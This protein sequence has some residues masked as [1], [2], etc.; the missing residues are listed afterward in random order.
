MGVYADATQ[1]P[2]TPEADVDMYVSTDPSLTNLNPLVVSNCVNGTQVGVS[3][4]G[5][6]NG[7]SLSS[8]GTQYVVD[9]GSV[10]GQTYYVG[11]KSETALAGEYGF[12]PVFSQQPFSQ[13]QNGIETVN[14]LLLP[15]LI[16]DGSPA[17]PGTRYVFALAIQPIEVQDVVVSN[18][19]WHQNF[20]DLIGTLSHNSTGVV[21]NNHDSLANPPGPYSF[22][23]YD[24]PQPPQTTVALNTQPTD[25]PGSLN[26]FQG[27]QGVGPWILTEVD[28]ALTHTGAVWG[29]TVT[30]T[31]HTPLN[32][33]INIS[34][35]A[36]GYFY[37]FIDVPVGTT[38]LTLS[39]TNVSG[40]V[41]D[42]NHYILETPP[43]GILYEKLGQ[44][45]APPPTPLTNYDQSVTVDILGGPFGP[46]GSI[47][48]TPYDI[49]PIE[50][51]R[52]YV[53]LYNP[54]AYAQQYQIWATLGIGQVQPVNFA[55]VG[56]VPLLDDAVSDAY[57]S[58]YPGPNATNETIAS[59]AVGIRVDHPRISDLVFTLI[60]PDGTRYLLMQNRG[61]TSTNGAGVTVVTTNIFSGSASGGPEGATNFYDLH[62]TSGTIPITWNFFT[63]AGH[64]GCLLSGHKH[65]QHG[66]DQRIGSH[67][68]HFWPR[69]LDA[70]R[71]GDGCHEPSG[72]HLVDLHHRRRA[73]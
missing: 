43:Y 64:H 40:S 35:S 48:V 47:F 20:G 56:S 42:P 19:I 28:D 52:Y 26:E 10:Q 49:P 18:L 59:I 61:N 13:T 44:Q 8:D 4:G 66:A 3:A 58:N 71:G 50:P 55:P 39:A 25:G 38:N 22:N 51:G 60:S 62:Q 6:F 15:T 30:L 2:T 1:N 45:P 17:H 65:F 41:L 57:I 16:P 36:Y 9:T 70:N 7:S 32:Q 14:G 72:L 46:G 37:G 63:G 23:Y 53:T 68:H 21:L 5:T 67:Q 27:Q 24:G 29:L 33:G 31:P 73:D 12:L 11:V 54:A 34:V 69:C